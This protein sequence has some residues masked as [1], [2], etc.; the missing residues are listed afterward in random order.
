MQCSVNKAM[1]TVFRNLIGSIII[2][3]LEQDET[4]NSASL[5]KNS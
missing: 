3:F 4:V 1:L 2:G 5:R